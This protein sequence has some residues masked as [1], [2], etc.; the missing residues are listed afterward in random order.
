[1][2]KQ[3]TILFWSIVIVVVIAAFSL[4]D[5]SLNRISLMPLSESHKVE[6]IPSPQTTPTQ[7]ATTSPS[8]IETIDLSKNAI[9]N[10][11]MCRNEKYGYEFKY[12]KGWYIYEHVFDNSEM[13]GYLKE[14]TICEGPNMTLSQHPTIK[15]GFI[16]ISISVVIQDINEW[17]NWLTQ[18][19]DSAT[20]IGVKFAIK[21]GLINGEKVKYYNEIGSSYATFFRNG[22]AFNFIVPEDTG[23]KRFSEL[24]L[25]YDTS[26]QKL[27]HAILSTFKFLN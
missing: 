24:T 4:Y 7:Q 14:T 20:R 10:W 25:S 19:T 22:K 3:K 8:F 1:M 15:G 16:P 23:G 21:E 27:L 17:E 5:F 9:A 26:E 13:G 12:P 11:S 18:K 2:L 6:P